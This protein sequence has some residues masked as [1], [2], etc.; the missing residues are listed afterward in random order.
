MRVIG[1]A[2]AERN[3]R[4]EFLGPSISVA[5]EEDL[6]VVTPQP[7]D[8]F[9]VPY[10][11]LD[12][13]GTFHTEPRSGHRVRTDGVVTLTARSGFFIMQQ[14]LRGIR[15]GVAEEAMPTD[16]D[17]VEVAGFLDMRRNVAGLAEASWRTNR[18]ELPAN[19]QSV[20]ARAHCSPAMSISP[21]IATSGGP[22]DWP[23]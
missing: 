19:P 2:G 17:R 4:G 22:S 8:P 10:L 3:T 23:L 16:G 18:L 1:V 11:P 21:P 13:L 14:G 6:V 5:R 9:A 20:F 12:A 7:S 15:V